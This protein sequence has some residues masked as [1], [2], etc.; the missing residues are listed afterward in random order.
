MEK[1]KINKY[2]MILYDCHQIRYYYPVLNFYY[3]TLQ[4]ANTLTL[5]YTSNKGK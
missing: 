2:E 3:Q 1:K 4:T 5:I